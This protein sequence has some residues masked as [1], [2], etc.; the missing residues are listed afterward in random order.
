MASLSLFFTLL[1]LHCVINLCHSQF[2]TTST[3]TY[4]STAVILIN[5]KQLL[6]TENSVS[7]F[8]DNMEYFIIGLSLFFICLCIT[9][10]AIIC[11]IRKNRNNQTRLRTLPS[12]TITMNDFS[13]DVGT[14]IIAPPS[15]QSPLSASTI[16][17][18]I[19]PRPEQSPGN[20]EPMHHQQKA[21]IYLYMLY[22]NSY[23]NLILICKTS[24]T[25][26]A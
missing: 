24:D 21:G 16:S 6:E 1:F 7:L 22:V 13:V 19:S 15:V 4:D 5:T 11:R 10:I 25:E 8:H 20:E 26:T 2:Q 3:T 17:F 18:P 23:N 12:T 9:N 14:N